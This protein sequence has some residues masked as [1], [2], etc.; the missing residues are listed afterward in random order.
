MVS[1]GGVAVKK[2]RA[3]VT[4]TVTNGPV[5]GTIAIE[6]KRK[7]KPNKPITNAPFTGTEGQ[8]TIT[9][10][11]KLK[12]GRYDLALTAAGQTL[13]ATFRVEMP[14]TSLAGNEL[15][16]GNLGTGDFIARYLKEKVSKERPMSIWTKRDTAVC[17]LH[18]VPL[19]TLSK[20]GVA[21]P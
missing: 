18:L 7:R 4:F 5:D 19:G 15:L 10:A 14:K 21:L 16:K 12:P 9:V 13:T 11:K 20:L 6:K 3:R 17:P 8:Q 2:K 1:L